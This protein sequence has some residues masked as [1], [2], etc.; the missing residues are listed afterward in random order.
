MPENQL[1]LGVYRDLANRA[2]GLPDD[3]QLARAAHQKLRLALK[4][5]L[6]EPCFSVLDWSETK[7][8]E[9]HDSVELV[10]AVVSSPTF[11][12]AVVPTA[13]F[14]DGILAQSQSSSMIDATKYLVV[15]LIPKMRW[16]EIG[17]FYIYLPDGTQ[18]SADTNCR[19][20]I[21]LRGG[22]R[23]TFDYERPPTWIK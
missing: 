22:P 20:S 4:E 10:V 2:L 23:V 8:I 5:E 13:I 21:S 14:L 17:G 19:I 6:T 12:D 18:V 7:D 1:R 16:H 9:P 3:G 11:Q 15:K